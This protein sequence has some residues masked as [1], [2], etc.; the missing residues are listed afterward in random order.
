[1]IIFGTVITAA[2]LPIIVLIGTLSHDKTLPSGLTAFEY[3]RFG[4]SELARNWS[5]G[6]PYFSNL[7]R[8]KESLEK[9][10]EI[11]RDGY[12]AKLAKQCEIS[13]LPSQIPTV[14]QKEL[15]EEALSG[16]ITDAESESLLRKCIETNPEFEW[17]YCSLA[18]LLIDRKEFGEAE[19]LLKKAAQM[20]SKSLKVLETE[21][22]LENAKGNIKR[23]LEL[24]SEAIN[25][26]P[27]LT[28]S[29]IDYLRNAI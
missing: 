4:A 10:I 29:Y 21:A 2:L 26:D 12:I 15:Y 13:E 17:P 19:T 27:F 16:H 28:S 5:G 9:A 3:Y 22:R 6:R 23:A 7:A 11:D 14:G 24:S 25:Q 18:D 20:N 8:A 1:M